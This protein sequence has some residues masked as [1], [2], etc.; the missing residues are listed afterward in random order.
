MSDRPLYVAGGIASRV[1]LFQKTGPILPLVPP[2]PQQTLNPP[3]RHLPPK[4]DR[5]LSPKL[6]TPIVPGTGPGP[7]KS[8]GAARVLVNGGQ[9]RGAPQNRPPGVSPAT[10]QGSKANGGNSVQD[11]AVGIMGPPT[12]SPSAKNHAK[13][14]PEAP[15]SLMPSRTEAEQI[16]NGCE[17]RPARRDALGGNQRPVNQTVK[18]NTRDTRPDASDYGAIPTGAN[19]WKAPPPKSNY[20]PIPMGPK[21]SSIATTNG[22]NP[23]VGGAPPVPDSV[24]GSEFA[25]APQRKRDGVEPRPKPPRPATKPTPMNNGTTQ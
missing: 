15:Y 21:P 24:Q 10:Q 13:Q 19:A 14:K 6:I 4:R 3:H 5:P 17:I 22:S 2:Q 8:A 25:A 23:T 18:G 20:G 1:D 12:T 7:F 11:K 9:Q 16:A